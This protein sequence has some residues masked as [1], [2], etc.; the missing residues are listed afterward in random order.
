M[1][2]SLSSR[3]AIAAS[4]A[5][6][7]S[8]A[9]AATFD[10]TIPTGGFTVNQYANVLGSDASGS[11]TGAVP[12]G[13]ITSEAGFKNI[14]LNA[15]AENLN[16][17][18]NN[19]GSAGNPYFDADSGGPGGLGSC[20]VLSASAQCVPNSD[21]NLTLAADEKIRMDFTLDNFTFTGATFG[22]F[23][24]HDDN[25]N[26][27][28][29]TVSV[30]HASGSSIIDINNGIADFS[31][32]GA[33]SWLVFNDDGGAGSTTNYYISEANISA[34]PVPAAVWL[35]GSALGLLGWRSRKA[36]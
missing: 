21:D 33:S 18:I 13:V 6:A 26:P 4:F 22:N 10:F 1:T 24:F 11:I 3:I 28:T 2:I 12:G 23:T 35:M 20:R 8:G 9:S 32:I 34:V 19:A 29:G 27:I 31:I 17:F 7:T 15:D 14:V 30:S 16:I 25:H 5:F 36:S